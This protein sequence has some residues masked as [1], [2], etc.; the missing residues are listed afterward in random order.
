MMAYAVELELLEKDPIKTL[1]WEPPDRVTYQVD[2]RSVINPYQGKKLLEAIGNRKPSG[3]LLKPFFALLYY[4]GLRPEEAVNVFEEDL[5][6]P[7]NDEEWG[8][9]YIHEATPDA[10]RAWT[11][12]G[13]IRD[14]RGLKHR[15][16]GDGRWVPVPP[17][18]VTILR[19]HK[20]ENGFGP[21]GRICYGLQ[22]GVLA[23]STIL[24]IFN[25]VREDAFTEA[26][27]K[28][29]LATRPYDL[30]HACL[31]TWLN[32]GVSITQVA[33]WAGNSPDVLS[34]VYAKCL[35]G[36]GAIDRAKISTVLDD[37]SWEMV[38]GPGSSSQIPAGG[39]SM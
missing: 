35:T 23:T 38:P 15:P 27:Q 28:S 26:E 17:P 8:E 37:R 32:A 33:E 5:T 25:Q 24:R 7:D 22:G 39:S 29:P 11:D 31:S 20:K 13:E 30:R 16:R 34:H 14:K 4:S 2:R 12:S 9:I 19:R 21:G 1:N 10:G 36:Q 3:P 6:L 18:L